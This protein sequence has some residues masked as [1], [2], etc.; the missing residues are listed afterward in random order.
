MASELKKGIFRSLLC[1]LGWLIEGGALWER[2]SDDAFLNAPVPKG[3][4]RNRRLDPA[5]PRAMAVEVSANV[6]GRTGGQLAKAMTR[7]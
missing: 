3:R 6:V 1:T 5:I 7:L 4:Q 2:A